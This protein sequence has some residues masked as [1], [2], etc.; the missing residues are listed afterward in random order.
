MISRR[1]FM[2][3]AAVVTATGALASWPL[4]EADAAG[5]ALELTACI[6]GS[7][8]DRATVLRW[9]AAR[10]QV[11]SQRLRNWLP[12][13]L[14]A[15]FDAFLDAAPSIATVDQD[16]ER[17]ADLKM[18]LGEDRIREILAV[19]LAVTGPASHL[20]AAT[21]SWA[22]SRAEVTSTLG[23][24]Q[25]FVTWFNS[26]I[27]A[28]DKHAMLV[29]CPDHYLIRTPGPGVQEVIEV[30]GGA[31]LGARFVIDYADTA[32]VPIAVD[33][34]FPVR[35][36]GWARDDCGTEIG[37]V[38]H[39]F[40]DNPRGGFR[41]KLAVA[42]PAVVPPEMISTHQWHLACEFSNWVTGYAASIRN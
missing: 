10:I 40:Q 3:T 16:R 28:D 30:T 13:A 6:D 17:L 5:P 14:L 9:E 4:P 27:N 21:G 20:A 26:R 18:G 29:A 39:Q 23:T 38:R 25:G 32:G 35:A 12:G 8:L 19:D 11:A 31:V 15:E 42:F 36:A 7:T 24:A 2:T 34:A 33:P 1:R 22:V 41:A 37:A